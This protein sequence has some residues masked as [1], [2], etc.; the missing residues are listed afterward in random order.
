MTNETF[1]KLT[2]EL[3]AHRKK[4]FAK[5]GANYNPN[6]DRL[7][8]INAV[9]QDSRV[10]A[11]TATLVLKNKHEAVIKDKVSKGEAFTKE[12]RLEM[13][14][15]IINYY[16]FINAILADFA[17]K[18]EFENEW[19]SDEEIA[20]RSIE[21]NKDPH[22]TDVYGQLVK[23]IP[24]V[25]DVLIRRLPKA[26]TKGIWQFR[27][28]KYKDKEYYAFKRGDYPE[29]SYWDICEIQ[30][31]PDINSPSI[32]ACDR[33]HP[34]IIYSLMNITDYNG[35][36]IDCS[37]IQDN[38]DFGNRK[39]WVIP[40]PEL[41]YTVRALIELNGYKIYDT[42]MGFISFS[43]MD[44]LYRIIEEQMVLYYIDKEIDNNYLY[45]GN[46]IKV[47]GNFLTIIQ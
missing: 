14:G 31:I 11:V 40:N 47:F 10:D 20:D 12:H 16:E 21:V 42:K 25:Y 13:V 45:R 23:V 30:P 9:A 41:C 1:E 7:E 3:T 22:I 38:Y 32:M 27:S 43:G 24:P 36:S 34:N 35:W 19:L 8:G 28:L 4:V 29:T 39:L 44:L 17:Q 33:P 5:K 37:T 18:K 2:E 46:G 6:G 15:D 26:S